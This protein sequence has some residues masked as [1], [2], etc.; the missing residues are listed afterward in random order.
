MPEAD[1]GGV[2]VEAEP[3]PHI[4]F[5]FVAMWQMAAEGQSDKM[6]SDLEV[7]MKQRSDTEFLRVEKMAPADIH[8]HLLN[9]C[10]D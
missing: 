3:S 10:G 7:W 5:C 2:A 9:I 8:W 6:V 4:P 1:F